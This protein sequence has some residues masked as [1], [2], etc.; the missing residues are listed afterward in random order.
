MRSFEVTTGNACT[1]TARRRD[2]A[3]TAVTHY[4]TGRGPRRM[5]V[6]FGTENPYDGA[7]STLIKELRYRVGQ[8]DPA[9]RTGELP[10]N[11]MIGISVVRTCVRDIHEHDQPED[12]VD[13]PRTERIASFVL[14]HSADA[15]ID[16]KPHP[17][18]ERRRPNDN[19]LAL[20]RPVGPGAEG[21]QDVKLQYLAV[22]PEEY[23]YHAMLAIPTL[24]ARGSASDIY[25][26]L[27][28]R[29]DSE[30]FVEQIVTLDELK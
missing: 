24:A 22:T 1:N 4:L 7:I 2:G 5:P 15:V 27:H 10:L 17:V 23:K 30:G 12:E 3:Y 11:K 18:G 13:T 14:A 25:V 19:G 6:R 8:Q 16:I 26:P 21:L 9:F 29:L 20:A 28:D